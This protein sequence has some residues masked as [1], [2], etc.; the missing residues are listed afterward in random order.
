M[1]LAFDA[2]KDELPIPTSKVPWNEWR[3]LLDGKNYYSI[4]P[5]KE[6]WRKAYGMQSGENK[7]LDIVNNLTVI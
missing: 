1:A 7:E 6:E 4:F 5:N 2:V 3:L